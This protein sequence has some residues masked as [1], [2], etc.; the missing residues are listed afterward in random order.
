MGTHNSLQVN[1]LIK[2]LKVNDEI[3]GQVGEPREPREAMDALIK[4]GKPAV[5]PLLELLKNPETWSIYYSVKVLGEIGDGRAVEPLIKLIDDENFWG[6]DCFDETIWALQKIGL[7]A[8][9]PMLNYL[10]DKKEKKETDEIIGALWVLEKIK[11]ERVYRALVDTLSYPYEEVQEATIASLKVYSDERAVKHLSRFLEDENFREDA[12]EAIKSLLYPVDPKR[13][14]SI[15]ATRGIIGEARIA[16]LEKQIFPLV[17]DMKYAYEFE[18]KFEGDDAQKLNNI[19]REHRIFTSIEKFLQEITELAVDEAVISNE[20]YEQ[21]KKIV[22]KELRE[23]RLNFEREHEEELNIIYWKIPDPVKE[24]KRSYKGLTRTYWGPNPKL[25][26]LC[27]RIWEWLKMQQ[28]LVT[29]RNKT[30]WGRKGNKDSRKGCYIHVGKDEEKARTWGLVHLIVWGS[31]WTENTTKT[32]TESFWDF[33]ETTGLVK[34][35][36]RLKELHTKKDAIIFMKVHGLKP[37]YGKGGLYFRPHIGKKRKKLLA[38]LLKVD[39]KEAVKT[40]R[41]KY[42]L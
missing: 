11:D 10:R 17:R 16:S 37:C 15:L 1:E 26:K 36:L 20:A 9:Q 19:A 28:F 13:Y 34:T 4:I 5:K 31:A 40:L 27:K 33:V 8:V 3:Y 18:K 38:D 39:S 30:F 22:D 2:A 24:E 42:G 21:I 41:E 12:K 23:A 6:T 25:D 14:R 7:P 32:F 35:E 29:K